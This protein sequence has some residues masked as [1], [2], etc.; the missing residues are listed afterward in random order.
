MLPSAWK[1]SLAEGSSR[2]ISDAM[3]GASTMYT[4]FLRVACRYA[5]A[6]SIVA[7]THPWRTAMHAKMN[8]AVME[9]V[10]EEISLSIS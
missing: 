8:R 3:K 1:N 5:E 6:K 9:I 7:I 10:D 4:V 2:T